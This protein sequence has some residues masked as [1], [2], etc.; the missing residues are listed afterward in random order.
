M[1][2]KVLVGLLLAAVSIAPSRAAEPDLILV[3]GKVVTAD[4]R[5]S[6]ADAVAVRGDRI[7]AVG[8][9]DKVRALSGASTRVI[10]LQGR[11]VLPGLIDTHIHF[12]RAASYWSKEARLDLV[13]TRKQ[14][15]ELLAAK[16]KSAQPGVWVL[17]IGGWSEH[18][19]EDGK[20]GF[21]LAELDAI[22]PAN[23]L[24]LQVDYSHAYV[25]SKALQA[26]GIPVDQA[27][28]DEVTGEVARAPGAAPGGIKIA[29]DVSGKATGLAEGIGSLLRLRRT[30]FQ[31][32]PED[33]ARSSA[34]AMAADFNRTGLTTVFD[35]GGGGTVPASYVPVRKL[36]EEGRL[37]L[38]IRHGLWITPQT[39]AEID[40]AIEQIKTTAPFRGNSMLDLIAVGE[41]IHFRL[42]DTPTDPINANP[43]YLADTR[44]VLLAAAE[45]GW[46]VQIHAHNAR[47][48][49]LFLDEIEKVDA[50]HSIKPLRWQFVHADGIGAAEIE[51]GRR[52]GIALSVSGSMILQAP[53]Y[54]KVLGERTYDMPPLRLIQDSGIRYALG[55]DATAV[56]VHNPFVTMWWAVTGKG[57][58]GQRVSNQTLTREEALLAY[59]RHAAY[60]LFEENNLGAIEPGKL[61]DLVV[62]D[63]DYLT[64]PADEI[65]DIKPTLVMVGGRVVYPR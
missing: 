42:V 54:Q 62:L 37:S 33:E 20:Q 41:L 59:T 52:L 39:T 48:I 11:A 25:N 46:P 22:A 6:I 53:W 60:L 56:A 57:I 29:R 19:F 64:V 65:R 44:R 26:A 38:R 51:R 15:L 4:D 36:A 30:I 50:V 34:L 63:R 14:A 18:Q 61:A 3:N 9:T 49:A 21:T 35:L 55:T 45:R 10:D 1:L 28:P 23:P 27:G 47:S 7:V 31:P 13:R 12:V 58:H 16:A 40:K 5:F 2:S 32:V 24:F 17:T 8:A 43:D